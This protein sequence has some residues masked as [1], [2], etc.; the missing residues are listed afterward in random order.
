MKQHNEG[1][2]TKTAFSTNKPTSWARDHIA[3][4]GTMGLEEAGN[5]E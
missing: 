5:F 2:V 1:L 3:I 4:T